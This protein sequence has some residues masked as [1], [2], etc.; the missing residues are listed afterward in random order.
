MEREKKRS[1][2]VALAKEKK[3]N[4]SFASLRQRGN[5]FQMCG[6]E[7]SRKRGKNTVKSPQ[8]LSV[9][10]NTVRGVCARICILE[11]KKKKK[12]KTKTKKKRVKQINV[13]SSVHESLG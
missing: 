11:K 2:D 12:R 10:T 5:E 8:R 7:K 9:S 1:S 4:R 6:D 13:F 3:R